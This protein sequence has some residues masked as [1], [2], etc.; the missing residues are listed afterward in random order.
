[1]I[2]TITL[3]LSVLIVGSIGCEPS[4]QEVVVE[5]YGGNNGTT[6]PSGQPDYTTFPSES[7]TEP[8]WTSEDSTEAFEA[9][10]QGDLATVKAKIEK[11]MPTNVRG[12][13]FREPLLSHAAR[14]GTAEIVRFLVSRGANVR[15]EFEPTSITPL[16]VAQ[17][18]G[19]LDVVKVLVENGADVNAKMKGIITSSVLQLALMNGDVEIIQYL[20]EK[21]ARPGSA[22]LRSALIGLDS[23]SVQ[24]MVDHGADVNAKNEYGQFPIQVAIEQFSII[25]NYSES[26]KRINDEQIRMIEILLEKGARVDV[27]DK[28]GR[29]LTQVVREKFG[30][31]GERE[32]VVDATEGAESVA[33]QELTESTTRKIHPVYRER[34]EEI[35]RL[36]GKRGAND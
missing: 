30:D 8:L 1:M 11:G 33:A 26:G 32:N 22:E 36:L 5:T 31:G 21:G 12:G 24:L 25:S 2:R 4:D 15:E 16:A 3:A 23:K 6:A 35:L 9:I 29:S 17:Q 20:I 27:K 14:H 18:R 13:E 7:G 10:E 34:K 19:N 28:D